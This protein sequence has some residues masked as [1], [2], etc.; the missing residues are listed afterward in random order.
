VRNWHQSQADW[1]PVFGPP[2]QWFS[3]YG[4]PGNFDGHVRAG[5][6]PGVD[7]DVPVGTPLVPAL[8]ACLAGMSEDWKGSRFVLMNSVSRPPFQVGYGHLDRA[9]V[10]SRYQTAKMPRPSSGPVRMLNRGEII[11]FSGNSGLG[12]PEYGGVQPPH[13]HLSTFWD[14]GK[15]P[16]R[17]LNLEKYGPDGGRPVFW[18]G[19]TPLDTDPGMRLLLLSQAL[20]DFE[21]NG[22]EWKGTA[23]AAEARANLLEFT[24]SLGRPASQK[25]LASKPFQ[26]LK[27]YLQRIVREQKRFVPGSAAYSLM[28]KVFSYS[29]DPGQEVILTL[30]FI[31]PGLEG[32]YRETIFE[33]GPF[34]KIP[35]E[36][37]QRFLQ[38]EGL[39]G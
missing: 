11:A 37:E 12:P 15:N 19:V 33:E 8:G 17:N 13:L 2:I 5:A 38:K 22:E 36:P 34:L 1:D 27:A 9:I 30:P 24:R 39:F 7:Y 20:R 25:I 16:Y 14:D 31:A 21:E 32:L 4:G 3:R 6:A 29:T 10:D 18:D 23:E 26:A 35:P 28:L